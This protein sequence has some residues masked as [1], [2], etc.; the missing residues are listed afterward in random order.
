MNNKFFVL[1]I[2]LMAM[3]VMAFGQKKFPKITAADFATPAEAA[4]T[5]VD[6]VF[7]YEIGETQFSADAVRFSLDTYVK[8]RIHILTEEGKEYANKA[9]TYRSSSKNANKDNDR[10]ESVNAAAYNL[11][12]GKVVK[13]SMPSK[14]VFRE[15]VNDD[16]MR[17][18]FTVPDV[19]VGT[20][21]EY[22]YMISSARCTDLPTWY[23]QKNE[24]VRYSYYSA[25]IPEWYNYHIED[26][27]YKIIKGEST[28]TTIILPSINAHLD[29]TKYVVEAENLR[30]F[31]GEDYIF[32]KADYMQR[33]DFELISVNSIE[34][35]IYKTYSQTWN[36]VREF[37]KE[38]GEYNKHLKI[39]NP[40]A[41]EMAALGLEGKTAS[42]KA[43]MIFALLK[44]KLK[45][46]ETYALVSDNPLKAVKEGKGSNADLNFIYMAMLRDAGIKCTPLLMRA[47]N[48]GRLP[49]T[50]ASIDKLNTFV[51]ALADDSG[52]LLFA[53][54]SA[55]YGD[56]NILPVNMLAEGV[57]YEPTLP[58]NMAS[59]PTR[60]EIYDLSG[61]GG[62]ISEAR[63]DAFVTPE[64]N[65][66][67]QRIYKHYGENALLYKDTY[68][69]HEDSLS[70]IDSKEKAL[71]C[72]LNKFTTKNVD[73]TGRIAEERIQ[74]SKDVVADGGKI[75]VNPLIFP[76]EKTNHFTKAERLLPIEFPYLQST[77][78]T[79]YLR[80]PE[81]YVLESMPE[82]QQIAME[83]YLSTSI[84]FEMN[85]NI[86]VTKYVSDVE[87]TFIPSDQYE[88]L[89]EYWNSLLKIN[90]MMVS[91][92]KQ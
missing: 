15:K 55:D 29:A 18:K 34:L 9:I 37:L 47:R 76:D 7:I 68:H 36:D 66:T 26:R 61:I 51:V 16:Y 39:K 70:M 69:E 63:I 65:L 40:Y 54:C 62:N 83:G 48:K 82:N 89:Q 43:S 86:L 31:K 8:T 24:P 44:S 60:G 80:I 78:I 46:D 33:V 6:A 79:T 30:P 25:T 42:T 49:L 11:V 87:N 1:A 72:K 75:Y 90:S 52:S 67:G 14:Y 71:E 41:Q 64:G 4:D 21:I 22:S 35:G 17:L 27:G 92:K 2:M 57:L 10:V 19:K 73:S 50:Y 85:G 91:M 5:T 28:P 58:T 38:E 13:T 88:K 81:G 56:V 59:Q 3:N 74:F 12:N 45:W 32:C 77:K 84:S 20:I 23:L 53:D